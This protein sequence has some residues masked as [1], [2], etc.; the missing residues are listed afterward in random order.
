MSERERVLLIGL[1]M[2]DAALVEAWAGNGTLPNLHAVMSG[3]TWGRLATTADVLHTST[4]PT[5]FTGV[6][7]G[8]HGVYYPYQPCPGSQTAQAIGP[9]QY[10]QP[11]VWEVLERAG[12]RSVVFDAPETFPADAFSGVQVFE[13]STWAWYWRRMTTPPG[14]EQALK[15]RFGDSP[16]RLEARRLGLAVPRADVLTRE[17]LDSTAAKA[18]VARWLMREHPWDLF[19]LVFA[20]P[21]PAGHYL[22]PAGTSPD[23]TAATTDERTKPVREIYAAVDAA[24]GLV[25]QGCPED[26]T[27]IVVSGDG[28][29]PNHCGW[30]LLP[31]VLR[32]AEFT[33]SATGA[34]TTNG[35]PAAGHR[36]L[37]QRVRDRIP[38][39]AR[40][41][42]SSRLPWR[43]RDRLVSRLA[44]DAIDWSRTVAFCLPTDLE[45][46]IRINVK[47]REPH[48][49][50][51]EGAHYDDVCA[52]LTEAARALVNPRTGT[53]AVREVCRVDRRFPGERR[54]HLPDVVL[55][56]AEGS[57]I[58]ELYSERT[59]LVTGAS[60]DPRTGTH[61]PRSFVAMQGPRVG[62]GTVREGHHIADVAPTLLSR[63]GVEPPAHMTGRVLRTITR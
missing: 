52:A 32:R 24:I 47:G 42:I 53:L 25:L 51:E 36:S 60:V 34:G 31:E 62:A 29:G 40:T 41:A 3:G 11:P 22:W 10:G 23:T 50:V 20:E 54:H 28:V 5:I 14:L 30:H 48:G 27:V 19:V 49:I 45:G 13:W 57:P 58:T 43:L 35:A 61:H 44:T 33:R 63:L 46:C 4:W 12:R 26:T 55:T 18:H 16:L 17:L 56:W 1:D 38:P 15:H 9:G 8:S 2:A 59:G 37:L 7:P 21:H 39:A 6:L